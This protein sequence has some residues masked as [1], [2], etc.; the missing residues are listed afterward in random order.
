MVADI[1]HEL[2]TPLAII[3]SSLDNLA[4]RPLDPTAQT[5]HQR[6]ADG[7]Q[8]LAGTLTAMSEARRV[9]ESITHAEPEVVNLAALLRDVGAAYRD[10]YRDHR[11]RVEGC[12]PE[13]ADPRVEA[14]PD[15]LVQ[16][17]DKLVDN[18]A[19]F[20]PAGGTITLTLA[21]DADTLTIAVSNDG[22]LLP[23]TMQS[24]LFDNMVSVRPQDD[25]TVHLGLGLHIVRLIADYH[26]GRIAA[27]NRAD[28]GGVVFSVHLPRTDAGPQRKTPGPGRASESD[29]DTER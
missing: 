17:L 26:G 13:P 7:T 28:A 25:D 1:A 27:R 14:A 19:G 29:R 23:E 16:M 5:F 24:Q 21:E 20:C 4:N 6:A 3:Q 11:I 10:L 22:P 12:A 18:A 9:E 15:L 8:R 2:R